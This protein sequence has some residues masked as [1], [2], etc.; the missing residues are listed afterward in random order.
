VA[1]ISTERQLTGPK[2]RQ[3]SDLFSQPSSSTN[4]FFQSPLQV[5]NLL[6]DD[7]ALQRAL[8]LLLPSSVRDSIIPELV[9]FGDKVLGREV[10]HFVADAEKNPPYLRTWDTWGKRRDELVTNEGW[11]NLQDLG[12]KEGVVSIDYEN[13]NG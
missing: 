12:I 13:R 2:Q 1:S 7:V 5:L 9:S 8:G 3:T 6:H 11:R 4:G 10:L